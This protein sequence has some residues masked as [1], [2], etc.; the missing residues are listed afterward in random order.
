VKRWLDENDPAAPRDVIEA[1]QNAT[2]DPFMENRV[3]ARIRA[4]RRGTLPA[5]RRRLRPAGMLAALAVLVLA[6]AASAMFWR[7]VKHRLTAAPPIIAPATKPSA[8][9]APAVVDVPAEPKI[10]APTPIE[11]PHKL[12]R[13]RAPTE[14][15]QPTEPALVENPATEAAESQLLLDAYR[16]LNRDHDRAAALRDVDKYLTDFP[17]GR[18]F[19]EALTLALE[20]S[21]DDPILAQRYAKKYLARFPDGSKAK[22]A[23]EILEKTE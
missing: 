4:V 21:T 19:E 12:V 2:V 15:A 10:V 16:A 20:A 6:S 14:M 1:L 13:P 23:T 11:P 17:H 8:P 9:S 3:L 22:R 18:L 5:R 7:A